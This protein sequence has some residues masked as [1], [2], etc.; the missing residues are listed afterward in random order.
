MSWYHE[1]DG[2]RAWYTNMGH[3]DATFTE[4]PFLKHLLGG[5]R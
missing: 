5:L 3:T 1:F 4:A 2:G